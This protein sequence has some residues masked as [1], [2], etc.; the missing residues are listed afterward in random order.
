MILADAR[1]AVLVDEVPHVSPFATAEHNYNTTFSNQ[2]IAI[3]YAIGAGIRAVSYPELRRVYSSRQYSLDRN[4]NH[5][6]K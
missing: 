5:Y 4:A 6:G 3:D 2:P 1:R